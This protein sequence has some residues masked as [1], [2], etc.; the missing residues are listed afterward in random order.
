MHYALCWC[1]VIIHMHRVHMYVAEPCVKK[2]PANEYVLHKN[3]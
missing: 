1:I 3:E 2:H